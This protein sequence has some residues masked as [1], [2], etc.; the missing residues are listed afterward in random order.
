MTTL[1]EFLLARIAEDEQWAREASRHD[2]EPIVD[3]GEHWRWEC[4]EH[5]IVITPDP[6]LDEFLQCTADS[7]HHGSASLRSAERYPYRS[8]SGEGPS[9]HFSTDEIR[10]AV[11]EHV[12]RWDPAR[13][14][15]ECAAKRRIVETYQR[16]VREFAE[17]KD[18]LDQWNLGRLRGMV[19]DLEYVVEELTTPYA[20]HPDYR[21][22][23]R[24]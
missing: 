16:H 17:A 8:I 3:G 10:P 4:N 2:E 24:P 11:A 21:Q 14:L 9:I 7:E 18:S 6:L 23:W 5:D 20:D 19:A 12:S 22:E 15:A 1:A 13:V